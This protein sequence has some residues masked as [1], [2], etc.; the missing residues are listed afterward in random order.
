MRSLELLDLEPRVILSNPAALQT[1]SFAAAFPAT[2]VSRLLFAVASCWQLCELLTGS[3]RLDSG[4]WKDS[5]RD[6]KV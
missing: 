6:L 1:L 4:R 2:V 3:C 5:E